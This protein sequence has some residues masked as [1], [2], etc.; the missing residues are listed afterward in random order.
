M[1]QAFY[2][3]ID[4]LFVLLAIIAFPRGAKHT[5]LLLDIK[6]SFGMNSP[7]VTSIPTTMVSRAESPQMATLGVSHMKVRVVS[8][9]GE[10]DKMASRQRKWETRPSTPYIK[11]NFPIDNVEMDS[12]EEQIS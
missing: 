10:K 1:S 11:G 9:T 4:L 6:H 12:D 7:P 3:A 8:P 5:P 2:L